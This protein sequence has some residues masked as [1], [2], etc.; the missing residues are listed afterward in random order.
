MGRKARP[1]DRVKKSWDDALN[2]FLKDNNS[3]AYA[4]ALEALIGAYGHLN[5]PVIVSMRTALSNVRAVETP[6]TIIV[7]DGGAA[8]SASTAAVDDAQMTLTFEGLALLAAA[9]PGTTVMH[10]PATTEGNDAGSASATATIERTFVAAMARLEAQFKEDG[11]LSHYITAL[12]QLVIRLPND[13]FPALA[14]ARVFLAEHANRLENPLAD[15]ET[16]AVPEQVAADS[17]SAPV[18]SNTASGFLATAFS[19]LSFGLLGDPAVNTATLPLPPTTEAEAEAEANAT[20]SL[21][22]PAA[23]DNTTEWVEV[24]TDAGLNESTLLLLTEVPAPD[25]S[26]GSS[27]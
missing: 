8:S 2:T 12:T 21:T 24:P 25:G 26:S 15:Y 22:V 14:G 5:L 13:N 23:F 20:M 1:E 18:S 6:P 17:S 4:A 10:M 19:Y 16:A 7:T 27:A 11:N 3:A 9:G